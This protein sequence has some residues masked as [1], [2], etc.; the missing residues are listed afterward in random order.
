MKRVYILIFTTGLIFLT[1]SIQ[2]Q[3][4]STKIGKQT[5]T[6]ENLNI[7]IPG[8]WVYNG[9]SDY[10][11][12]YGRLYT[13]EAAQKACPTGWRLPT[14]TDWDELVNA[15][16]GEDVAA[17]KLQP[18]GQTGFNALLGGY[19][20]GSSFW[21]IESYGGFWSATSYDE[22]H[23]WY[24]FFTKK[25]DSLTKTYFSKNYGFSVRCVKNDNQNYASK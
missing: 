12:K 15:L 25:D 7:N 3:L 23:A 2:A 14:D 10:E 24:R 19:A 5:W 16:G 11:Q 6:A 8:S 13:W 4:K 17:K 22:N 20:N 1:N 18:Q 21:F 9:R